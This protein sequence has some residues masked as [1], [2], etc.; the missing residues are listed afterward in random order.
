MVVTTGKLILGIIIK[1]VLLKEPELQ[2]GMN[3]SDYQSEWSA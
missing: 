1:M 3:N 2:N